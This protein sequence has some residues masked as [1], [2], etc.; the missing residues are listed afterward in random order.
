MVHGECDVTQCTAIWRRPNDFCHSTPNRMALFRFQ[1]SSCPKIRFF[2]SSFIIPSNAFQ[3]HDE[4]ENKNCDENA[5]RCINLIR[6]FSFMKSS[7][8]IETNYHDFVVAWVVCHIAIVRWFQ[9]LLEL[10]LNCS[11]AVTDGKILIFER[12][13]VCAA[14][15]KACVMIAIIWILGTEVKSQRNKFSLK[16]VC[17]CSIFVRPLQSANFDYIPHSK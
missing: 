14:P 10:Q 16:S 6:S 9:V 4:N 7:S 8:T 17:V 13:A 12:I 2:G 11:L 15:Y 1:Y 5:R 3:V